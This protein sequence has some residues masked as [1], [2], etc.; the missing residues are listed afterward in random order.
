MEDEGEEK[1]KQET[2]TPPIDQ[3]TA[4]KGGHMESMQETQAAPKIRLIPG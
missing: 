4:R 3:A 1:R 2:E